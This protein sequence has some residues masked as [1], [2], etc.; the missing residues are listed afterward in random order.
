MTTE[1]GEIGVWQDCP[2]DQRRLQVSDKN[3]FKTKIVMFKMVLSAFNCLKRLTGH[4]ARLCQ[5][6]AHEVY[7]NSLI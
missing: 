6:S 4:L 7:N 5:S 2:V 3:D 1:H